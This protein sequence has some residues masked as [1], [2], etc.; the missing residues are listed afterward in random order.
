[1][2]NEQ[3][4][5]KTRYKFPIGGILCIVMG[6][7][8]GISTL[9]NLLRYVFTTGRAILVLHFGGSGL[10]GDLDIGEFF[11]V[12]FYSISNMPAFWLN[13]GVNL[14]GFVLSLIGALLFAVLGIMLIARLHGKLL[15]IIPI[16]QIVISGFSILHFVYVLVMNILNLLTGYDL[17][18]VLL[19]FINNVRL[20]GLLATLLT[21]LGWVLLAVVIFV[22]C[23]KERNAEDS[24]KM[25]LLAW[26]TP[27]AFAA[28]R[29]LSGLGSV[30]YALISV[31]GSLFLHISF[32][33]PVIPTLLNGL[34]GGLLS[35]VMAALL[36]ATF[37]F[38]T[39]WIIEP[40]KK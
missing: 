16:A 2:N 40:R 15:A 33:S 22:N 10:L 35:V 37:Y 21:L 14:A 19:S 13:V 8:S 26:L 1:M 3:S 12:I 9:L 5:T 11:E 36:A 17:A 24:G 32:G 30:I 18:S 34:G 31:L 7:V 6:I 38:V 4:V 23:N 39:D 20:D 27:G 29:L 28:S 25:K